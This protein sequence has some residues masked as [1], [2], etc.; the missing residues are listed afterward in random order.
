[1]EHIIQFGVTLDDDAIKKHI[2]EKATEYILKDAKRA[3]G[4]DSPFYRNENVVEK[5]VN[6]EVDKLFANL[7]EEIIDKTSEKLVGRLMKSKKVRDTTDK[8]LK[9]VFEGGSDGKTE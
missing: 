3:L 7:K 8:A 1:M 2:L 9:D 5:M 4:I 6:E